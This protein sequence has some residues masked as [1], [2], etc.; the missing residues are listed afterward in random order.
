MDS[1]LEPESK[2]FSLICQL[3]LLKRNDMVWNSNAILHIT[4]IISLVSSMDLDSQ[5]KPKSELMLLVTQTMSYFKSMD[6]DT[7]PEL[8]S[9]LISVIKRTVSLFKSSDLYSEPEPLPKLKSLI[10]QEHSLAESL[11]SLLVHRTLYLKPEPEIMSLIYRIL[12]LVVSMNSKWN[13]LISLC[14]KVEGRFDVQGKFCVMEKFKRTKK[15]KWRCLPENWEI[16]SLTAENDT[17]FH[18]EGC[19]GE[20]HE[21]YEKAPNEIIKY[22]LHPKHPLQLVLLGKYCKTKKCYCCEENLHRF[23]Y[24]CWVCHF[25]IN[26]ACLEK[27][28]ALSIDHPEWHKHPLV[29]FP[30]H[31]SLNCDMCALVDSSSPL[32]ICLTCDFVV[33]QRCMSLP[34]VIRISRHPHRIS[35]TPSFDQGEWTCGVCRR[36]ID[37]DY[38]GYSCIK[39]GCSYGVHSKCAIQRNVWDG[40]ELEGEREEIEE[41]VPES[42]VRISKG[43]IQHFSHEHHHLKL[44]EDKSRDYDE[45]KLCQACI[46]PIYFGNFYSCMQCDY[47]LHETCAK[48]SRKLHHPIH[49]H[50]L[51]LMGGCEG[52]LDYKESLCSACPWMCTSGFFYECGKEECRFKVHVQCATI[53]EPLVHGSHNHPLFLTS[54]PGERRNCSICKAS[55]YFPTNETFNCLECDFALCFKCATFPQKVR[56]K[57][58]KHVLTLFYGE[59][60]STMTYWCEVCEHKINPKGRFYKCDEYCCVTLHINCLIGNDFYMKPGIKCLIGDDFYMKPGSNVHEGTPVSTLPNNHHM[61]RPICS[62]CEMRCP[63]K[64]FVQFSGL[65]FC[66]V[67]CTFFGN[68]NIA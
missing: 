66:S 52:V 7:Q 68:N 57:H 18:C 39:K 14:P 67:A 51:T 33:H 5:S 48:L 8:L 53:S 45:K 40:K 6:L 10:T 43:I 19:K 15:E 55:R 26:I 1:D 23:F 54:K 50:L 63:Y 16:F 46:T 44:D 34:H 29:H 35:F 38:G 30:R 36:K 4:Q 25:A 2:L 61:S 21:E 31:A 58:D 42:F 27:P 9:E 24:Y 62:H 32:Y 28:P 12:S 41:E 64:I 37:N 56:Y 60:S 22:P 47:K 59:K 20:N 11:D 17:H 49:P 65:K 13:K 3:L